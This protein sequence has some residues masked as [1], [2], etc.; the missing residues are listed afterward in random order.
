MHIL[1]KAVFIV[2]SVV[3]V[4]IVLG[5]F[6]LQI[7]P[8]SF[9]PFPQRTPPLAT[10]PLP[11]GLP[12]PVE[13]FYRQVYGDSVPVITSAVIT[14]R[15]TMRPFG[16]I[17][18]PARFRFI[19]NAGKDYRHYIEATIF[20][21]PLLTVNEHFLDGKGRLELPFGIDKGEKIDQGATLG[22]W[23]ESVWLPSI[24]IT[25]SRVSWQP[26]DDNMA[27][28]TVPSA[29]GGERFVVRF[30][31]DTG[32]IT[33]FE[34]MRYHSSTS[35]SKVLWLNHTVEWGKQ[36]GKPFAVKG[37]AIWM[38]DGKPWAVFTVEDVVYN[39]DVHEYIRAKGL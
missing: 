30:D 36:D 10:I 3:A 29:E 35:Q 39:V 11:K 32:L 12:T 34:S 33:W 18:F 26:V 2:A 13:R 37:A 4:L 19:H 22:L 15:A 21:I 38:D 25:D 23:A 6:G 17:T 27:I 24:Y 8:R 5:W 20:G 28:L 14:G 1:Q 31:P 16:A 9:P 7:K